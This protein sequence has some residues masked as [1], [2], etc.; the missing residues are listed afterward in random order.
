MSSVPRGGG[1]V[2]TLVSGLNR[3]YGI[4]VDATHVYWTNNGDGRVMKLSPK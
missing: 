2:T 4:A 3:P 1:T